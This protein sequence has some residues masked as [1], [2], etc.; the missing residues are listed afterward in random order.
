MQRRV[1]RRLGRPS[2][3]LSDS[4]RVARAGAILAMAWAGVL[5]PAN[6]FASCGNESLRRGP[7]VAL[8]DC[9]AYEQVS[10]VA[11]GGIDAARRGV[12]L[13]P[14]QSSPNGEGVAYMGDG[15]FSGAVGSVLP[16]V[17]V[18]S[19]GAAS[20]S[21]LDSTPP[22]VTGVPAGGVPGGYDFSED[23][24]TVAIKISNDPL[25]PGMPS[26]TEGLYNLFLH[27]PDGTYSLVNSLAPTQFP[28]GEC[29]GCSQLIDLIAF[30]GASSNFSHVLFETDDI[31]EGTGASATFPNANLYE[32][33]GG[34]V[35]LVGVLPDGTAAAEGAV[36]GAGGSVFGGIFYSSFEN[37]P[38]QWFRVD[39]AISADGSRVV[40]QAAADGGEP[41]AAQSGFQEVYDRIE[42][43]R[44]V[45]VSAPMPG[46]E[47]AKCETQG[48]FC[49]P[50]GAQFWAAS[51]DGSIVYFASKASLTKES[52]TGPELSQEARKTKEEERKSKEE[53]TEEPGERSV[54]PGNDLYSYNVNS[55][56]LKDITVDTT[57]PNGAEVLGVVDASRDGSY[58]YFVAKGELVNRQRSLRP[59]QS[60]RGTRRLRKS[61]R[62]SE[63]HR[64]AHLGRL[65]G[66]GG[67][68]G[69]TR[70]LC[71]SRREAFGLHV[72]WQSHG[73]R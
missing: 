25:V 20:W 48:G 45:E 61:R 3:S 49:E 42:G 52:F 19:R 2:V 59:A 31:L 53:Q 62:R 54:N 8:P 9:R 30:A 70:G 21:T 67:H 56:T 22:T 11:K 4:V 63:V 32:S 36:P 37:G 55:G 39:H 28:P 50:E 71:E 64:D 24:S 40:F 72:G 26:G 16:D 44:T 41:D 69:R 6:A 15:P 14:A 43:S 51:V 27:H 73:V 33:S 46:A 35:R 38:K 7:S 34:S 29:E 57:D 60:V 68:P 10:P 5:A 58:V 23:L 47:P 13:Y 18:S 65:Q 1:R 12:G 66:L 17:R